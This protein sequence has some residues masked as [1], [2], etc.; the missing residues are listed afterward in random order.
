MGRFYF[1]VL[2]V[3]VIISCKEE[4]KEWFFE[5]KIELPENSRPLSLAKTGDEL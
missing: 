4:K 5:G 2:L 3:I 1:L